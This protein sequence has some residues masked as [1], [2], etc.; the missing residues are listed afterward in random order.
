MSFDLHVAN[1]VGIDLVHR[2]TPIRFARAVS[3]RP[4]DTAPDIDDRG[5]IL[6]GGFC[7]ARGPVV[8]VKKGKTVRIKVIRDRLEPA[9][10]LFVSTA[11]D[12]IAHIEHPITDQALNTNDIAAIAAVPEVVASPGVAAR[13]AVAAVPERKGDC[14]YIHGSSTSRS[15]QETL[16]KIHYGAQDGP[17][18]AEIA[19]RVMPVLVINVQAH[20]VAINTGNQTVANLNTIRRLFRRVNRIYAQ[21]GIYFRLR[22]NLLNEVVNGFANNDS[23]T[24]PNLND[25]GNV[26]L[27]T[28]LNQNPRKNHLNA[29]FI[30]NYV[31]TTFAPAQVNGVLGIAFSS[32]IAN[33]NPPTP[34][35]PG[36]QAGITSIITADL[37]E[38]AHVIAH[39]IGHSLT[40]NHCR[41]RGQNTDP[42]DQWSHRNL[43]F[44]QVGIGTSATTDDVGY[45]NYANGTRATGTLLTTKRL[46][47]VQ[48]SDQANRVRRAK[49]NGACNP[50]RLP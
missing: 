1:Q 18:L 29:Y 30:S 15:S 39:E 9:T 50:V 26:E 33:A 28:V 22:P 41:L 20:S 16:V 36:T 7:T 10:Q 24:L 5:F 46:R 42:N 32:T 49:L 27:Q 19:V 37:D 13:P 47:G 44:F 35:F 23:V 11:D 8:G 3:G 12:S 14:I 25:S 43:M 2:V 48:Q 40:L 21:T 34:G 31:D 4:D 38:T 45:G 6:P 17:V